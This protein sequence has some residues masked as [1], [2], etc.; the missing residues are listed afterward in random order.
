[1]LNLKPK[2][3]VGTEDQVRQET[4]QRANTDERV[5]ERTLIKEHD[6]VETQENITFL[7][8]KNI[9]QEI[10]GSY[11]DRMSQPRTIHLT[12]TLDKRPEVV[13]TGFWNGKFIQAAMNAIARQYRQR[14]IV[15]AKTLGGNGDVRPN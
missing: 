2:T 12:M 9:Y 10:G 7:K 6:S 11:D 8:S 13:F 1:M 15:V 5:A 4:V 3:Q 14:R